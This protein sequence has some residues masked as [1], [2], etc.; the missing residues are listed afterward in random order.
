MKIVRFLL[1][2]VGLF[3]VLC[4]SAFAGAAVYY[5]APLSEMLKTA[6]GIVVFLNI[7]CP[8]LFTASWSKRLLYTAPVLV[9]FF[10]WYL[11]IKPKMEAP[12]SKDVSVLP[13]VQVEGDKLIVKNIRN[14]HYR[15][16]ADYDVSYYDKTYD[17][18]QVQTM[19]LFLSYWGTTSI[20]HTIMSF[21][22]ANGDHLA[23]SIEVRR[24][25]GEEYSAVQGFFKK[26][27]LIYVL[28]DERDVVGVRVNQRSEDVYLYRLKPNPEQTRKVLMSYIKTVQELDRG[29]KFY[30]A[31]TTNCTTS[32][33]PHFEAMG[34]KLKFNIAMIENG[35]ID[36][37]RYDSGIWGF[38]IPFEEFRRRSHI[39]DKVKQ[40]IDAPD[41][42]AKIR[43]G[44]PSIEYLSRQ[45]N[46][47]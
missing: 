27:E 43:E 33:L 24:K 12:W 1:K 4:L 34:S 10:G 44:L 39:N 47:H 36:K 2:A 7:L 11:S 46:N 41:F 19:D 20:A 37:W 25:I 35:F 9:V 13:S 31:L 29:P 8:F 18:S 45:E 28:V 5:C 21:G 26:F 22:F 23:V 38:E 42:S 17:L 14:F 32:I 15:T 30:N 6:I 40:A 3:L 16:D